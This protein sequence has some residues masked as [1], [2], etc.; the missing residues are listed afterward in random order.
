MELLIVISV[1]T[2]IGA[3]LA[4]IAVSAKGLIR[5]D[6]R[7]K[8]LFESEFKLWCDSEGEYRTTHE[9][10]RILVAHVNKTQLTELQTV[11]LLS[12][13]I[14]YGDRSM[15]W[16]IEIAKDSESAIGVL[17]SLLVGPQIRVGWRAEYALSRMNSDTVHNYILSF[18]TNHEEL[19]EQIKLPMKRILSNSTEK[20]LIEMMTECDVMTRNKA[21]EV[22]KQIRS[23]PLVFHHVPKAHKEQNT[24]AVIFPKQKQRIVN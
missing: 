6:K 15:H 24:S 16:L 2:G 7:K 14:I 11:F 3:S 10:L 9:T 18:R 8:R 19:A 20:Y 22:V 17:F 4:T 21:E 12:Q 23:K 5:R 1:I 13:S